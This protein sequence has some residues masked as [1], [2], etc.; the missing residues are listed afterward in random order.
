MTDRYDRYGPPSRREFLKASTVFALMPT[1]HLSAR[2]EAK[3]Q[4]RDDEEAR[5]P[6][7]PAQPTSPVWM[8]DLIIYEVATKGFTSPNGPESGTFAS[9]QSQLS[10]LHELGITGLW[11]TGYSLCDPHHFYNVWTQYAVIEPDRF[12][13]SL[14]TAEEFKSLIDEAHRLGI[15]IFL[16][17]ITHGL[18]K[19]SPVIRKHPAWFRGGS[20]G[21]T[22]F[23]WDGGHTDLDDWWV[24]IY[25]EF[26]TVYGVDGYRLDVAIFRPDLWER[27]RRNA[28]SA[29][30]PIAIWEEENSVIRGVTDFTQHESII[31][32][33]QIKDGDLNKKLVNDLPG[34]YDRKF[35]RTGCYQVEI[36]YEDES[37]A[38][39][40]SDGNGP[41]GV[42]L[43]GLSADR[44]GRRKGDGSARPDGLPDVQIRLE[45]VSR[46]PIADITVRDGMGEQWK[47]RSGRLLVVDAPEF[48]APLVVGP[49]VDIYIATLSWGGA[50]QLS[51]HDNGWEGFPLDKSPFVAK[52]SRSVFGYSFMFSP[53]IPIFFS[54]EEFDATFHALPKLSPALFGS[55]DAGK[56]RWLYG[57]MLDWNEVNEPKHRDMLV[58]VKKMIDIRKQYSRILAMWPPG[59]VPNLKAVHHEA[60]IDVPVPYMRWDDHAAVVI[61]ANRNRALDAHMKLQ[62]DIC[63]IELGGH[64]S[65]LVTDLW[66]TSGTRRYS[67]AELREFHCGTKRDGTLGGGLSVFK[68]EP[69][70]SSS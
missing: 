70:S 15:R 66:S 13:P 61:A 55:K 39:G 10:Y 54:G 21:M 16:D 32:T 2:S 6:I 47:L 20:W 62:I 40:A 5:W 14:G 23:D 68:I 11:L 49:A 64:N 4:P 56:G 58:D 29:G 38:K 22:D 67:E 52:G 33:S 7:D 8:R 41:L 17:V 9:L 60:D 24:K 26:V 48:L 51:C 31:S 65:Y 44:V 46:K 63:D 27:I 28:T 45:N 1:I 37:I 43:V 53:M 18:M 12:D 36:K 50:I 30:H 35:G 34:F 59:S 69:A 42:R 25:T 19:D 3:V 57:A